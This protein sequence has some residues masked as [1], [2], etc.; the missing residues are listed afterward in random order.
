M[1]VENRPVVGVVEDSDDDFV[2]FARVFRDEW[3]LRR[4]TTGEEAIEE[5]RRD[6][7][8]LGELAVLVVDLSLAGIAGDEVVQR[9]REFPEGRQLPVCVFTGSRRDADRR[10]GMDTGADAFLV[11][12]SDAERLRQLPELL[13]QLAGRREGRR[14]P[15]PRD[16]AEPET[17]DRRR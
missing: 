8:R 1:D 3:D 15:A 17:R 13:A 2:L 12:P 6:S 5:F 11:K 9:V 16:A 4:W 10:R 7:R 14:H